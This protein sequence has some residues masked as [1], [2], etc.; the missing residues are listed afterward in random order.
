MQEKNAIADKTF[1]Y[2]PAGLMILSCSAF[3]LPN[4]PL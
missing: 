4:K 1:S 3:I 2:L